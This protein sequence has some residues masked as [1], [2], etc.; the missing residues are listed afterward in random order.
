MIS[1]IDFD[2][3]SHANKWHWLAK[4]SLWIIALAVFISEAVPFISYLVSE[5]RTFF[6]FQQTQPS[7]ES[8]RNGLAFAHR[9]APFLVQVTLL[10][11]VFSILGK[12]LNTPNISWIVILSGAINV[13]GIFSS[14]IYET[15]INAAII[16]IIG[17]GLFDTYKKRRMGSIFGTL[18]ATSLL[19]M[20]LIVHLFIVIGIEGSMRSV[21]TQTLGEYIGA[22]SKG[23]EDR[24][25]PMSGYDC[26][27]ISGC[28]EYLNNNTHLRAAVHGVCMGMRK[29]MPGSNHVLTIKA[30]DDI[31]LIGYLRGKISD[32][33]IVDVRHTRNHAKVE[34]LMSALVFLLSTVISLSGVALVNIH[35]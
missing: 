31:H 17:F 35:R 14:D 16:A 8:L 21:A 3:L 20:L 1:K 10:I 34:I 13:L 32:L 26:Q 12:R 19:G 18:I 2:Y 28:D 29:S 15:L 23:H 9:A 11:A 4:V 5:Y 33:V 7:L 6:G 22:M 27:R 24:A 30:K 25:C